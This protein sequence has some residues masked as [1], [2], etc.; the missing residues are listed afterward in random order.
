MTMLRKF[1]E[2]ERVYKPYEVPDEWH[3][4]CFENDMNTIVN[5]AQCGKA[6]TCGESYTS[7]QVHTSLGFGYCVCVDCYRKEFESRIKACNC[8]G[9]ANE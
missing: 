1:D 2:T 4:S 8:Q 3:V 7:M 6:I 5:C 9:V